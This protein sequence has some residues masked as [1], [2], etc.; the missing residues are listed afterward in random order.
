MTKSPGNRLAPDN[1]HP[2]PQGWSTGQP[3]GS[4][5]LAIGEF[6]RLTVL[7]LAAHGG[8]HGR[9]VLQLAGPDRALLYTVVA[10]TGLQAIGLASLTRHSFR[11]DDETPLVTVQT[12]YSKH[13][14]QDVL[15]LYPSLVAQLRPWIAA[16]PEWGRI[17]PG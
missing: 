8:R 2:P 12:A 11:L 9:T 7:L 17:W 13:R 15:P 16:K 3:C 1:A 10:Y 14:R 6:L 5:S 4:F